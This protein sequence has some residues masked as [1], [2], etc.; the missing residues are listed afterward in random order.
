MNTS[1][2]IG[3]CL[4]AWFHGMACGVV[5]SCLPTLLKHGR[6]RAAVAMSKDQTEW[7]CP[8]CGNVQAGGRFVCEKCGHNFGTMKEQT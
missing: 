4:W 2:I 1:H 5:F 7:K 3:Y 8:D 6:A